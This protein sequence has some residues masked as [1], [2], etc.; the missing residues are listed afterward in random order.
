MIGSSL[1]ESPTVTSIPSSSSTSLSPPSS[2]SRPSPSSSL[3]APNVVIVRRVC[4]FRL[5]FW[6]RSL[7]TEWITRWVRAWV[8]A[9]ATEWMVLLARMPHGAIPECEH[10]SANVC[11]QFRRALL[12]HCWHRHCVRVWLS[13]NE[14]DLAEVYEVLGVKCVGFVKVAVDQVHD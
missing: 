11:A 13:H 8:E 1:M 14:L 9:S 6:C 2:P 4:L 10:F 3:P 12:Q 7:S 5:W